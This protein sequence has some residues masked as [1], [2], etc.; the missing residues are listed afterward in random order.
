M[1]LHCSEYGC[2]GSPKNSCPCDKTKNF[3]EFHI[4][5]HLKL[6]GDHSKYPLGS[7]IS[8][9][10]LLTH[11]MKQLSSTMSKVMST[12]RDMFQEICRKLCEITSELT[13]RQDKLIEMASNLS[14]NEFLP[15]V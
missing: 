13:E 9:S 10:T 11:E 8:T 5:Q 14:T 15:E 12:G 4:D 2:R 3:C 6:E 7:T 1:D